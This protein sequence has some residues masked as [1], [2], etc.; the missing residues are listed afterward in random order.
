[1]VTFSRRFYFFNKL[2]LPDLTSSRRL[3]INTAAFSVFPAVYANQLLLS[4]P[5][6]WRLSHFIIL[7]VTLRK[8]QTSSCAKQTPL[9]F[10]M[11]S[12]TQIFHFPLRKDKIPTHCETGH[13]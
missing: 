4:P 3:L 8:I 1:M 12:G 13:I 5:G 9:L 2:I 7:T 10:I 6:L 11:I